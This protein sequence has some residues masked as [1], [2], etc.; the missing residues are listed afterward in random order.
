MDHP[1]SRPV[2]NYGQALLTSLKLGLT[3]YGMGAI[4]GAPKGAVKMSCRHK[5]GYSGPNRNLKVVPLL[6]PHMKEGR[7]TNL[8]KGVE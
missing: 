5:S 2:G 6:V 3:A 4:L 7:E 1:L 8:T